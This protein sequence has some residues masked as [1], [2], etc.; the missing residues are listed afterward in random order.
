MFIFAVV[1]YADDNDYEKMRVFEKMFDET[2]KI[3][4][5]VQEFWIT[6][7][8]DFSGQLIEGIN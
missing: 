4:D 6:K 1:K 3:K 5:S 2:V 7:I 8:L